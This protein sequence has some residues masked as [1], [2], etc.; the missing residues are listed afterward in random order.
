M[1]RSL[2]MLFVLC[3]VALTAGCGVS[4]RKTQ[5]F[6]NP[7]IPTEGFRTV[8][9]FV[10]GVPYPIA[11]RDESEIVKAFQKRTKAQVFSLSEWSTSGTNIKALMEKYKVDG[12][13]RIMLRDQGG[14]DMRPM[15]GKPPEGGPMPG[16]REERPK[17]RAVVA[18]SDSLDFQINFDPKNDSDIAFLLGMKMLPLEMEEIIQP[19]SNIMIPVLN[20]SFSASSKDLDE[21]TKQM[22]PCANLFI[23]AMVE[24]KLIE[25]IK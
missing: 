9:V 8:L 12:F 11:L 10:E 20:I 14:R 13:I 18:D 21:Q 17:N 22:E 4:V 5:Y 3:I 25:P 15:G 19:E 7:L 24:K 2:V 6:M 16:G 23:D 1:K